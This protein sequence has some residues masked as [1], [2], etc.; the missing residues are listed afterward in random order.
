[1]CLSTTT[2]SLLIRTA[3]KK[4]LTA[5]INFQ[6]FRMFN[7]RTFNFQTKIFGRNYYRFRTI[8]DKISDIFKQVNKTSDIC[9]LITSRQIK[10]HFHFNRNSQN[11]CDLRV[12]HSK[13]LR[14]QY[15]L[16]PY[17]HEFRLFIQPMK[18]CLL[19]IARG[20]FV[21]LFRDVVF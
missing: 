16:Q 20:A 8:S 17:S 6:N 2:M 12:L 4:L 15:T 3:N 7:F 14:I 21:S 10:A 18:I 13:R 19:L 1:M 5:Y 9:D 11:E